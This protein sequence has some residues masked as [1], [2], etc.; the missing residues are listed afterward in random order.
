MK[1]FHFLILAACFST[2]VTAEEI[3]L[4]PYLDAAV[5]EANPTTNYAKGDLAIGKTAGLAWE[6]FLQFDVGSLPANA[7]LTAAELRLASPVGFGSG[8]GLQ[9]SVSAAGWAETILAWSNR[10]VVA[11]LADAVLVVDGANTA[12]LPLPAPVLAHLQDIVRRAS[13]NRGLK[14]SF[15]TAAA[16]QLLTL[17]S[18]ESTSRPQLVITYELD[19]ELPS[20]LAVQPKDDGRLRAAIFK[21]PAGAPA[22]LELVWNTTPG[23]RYSLWESPDLSSWSEVSG[24]PA[25]A[26]ALSG[27]HEIQTTPP[28][29]FF[30]VELID[31][32]PP[33]IVSRSPDDGS[34]GIKRYYPSEEIG[35]RLKDSTGINPAS[36]SLT[37]GGV[38]TFTTASP[39]LTYNDGLLTLDLGGDTPL[40][41]YGAMINASLTVAD[42]LGNAATYDWS[43][44]LEREIVL[45]DGLFTFGSP[46]AQRTG[47]RVPPIPTR[48]LADRAGGGGPIRMNDAEWTL[49]SVNAGSLVIA[50]TGTSAPVFSID[51]YLTNMTPATLDEIFYRKVTSIQDNAATKKLTLGTV[52]VPA[53]EIVTEASVSLSEDDIAFEADADGRIIRAYQM[54]SYS[55]GD[56][57]FS[58]DP[59]QIDWSDKEVMGLYENSSGSTTAV[60]GLPI[61]DRPPQ[62]DEEWDCKLKLKQAVLRLRPS[63]SLSVETRRFLL[64]LK[65]LHSECTVE[66]DTV[67]EPE[68][69]FIVPSIDFDLDNEVNK[70]PLIK[71]DF[72][73]PM[74]TTGIW[75]TVSPRLRAEASLTAGLTGTVSVGASG[76][77]SQTMVIDYNKDNDPRLDISAKDGDA[78]FDLIEPEIALGGT[79]G[80]EFKL[81]P[82]I[83]VKVNSLAGFYVNFDP[84]LG[85]DLNADFNSNTLVGADVGLTF[86]GHVN[87]GMSVI[88]V[89]NSLLPSFEPWEVFD[90][91]WRWYF[92]ESLG[93]EPLQIL[94][95]PASQTIPPGDN[96]QLSVQANHE[97]GVTYEWRHNG[98]R[99]FN[100]SPTLKL[101]SVTS[102]AAGDYKVILRYGS[103]EVESAV[104]TVTVAAPPP[105]TNEFAL[106]PA[107]SFQMGDSL[108]GLSNAPVHS[109]YVSEFYM[110]RYE[111]TKELWDTVRAW[112]L[113]NDY[114]DLAVGSGSY[115]SKGA[116]HPV[117]SISWYDMVK[118]CNARSAMENRTPC[119]RVD[120]A[121]YK[122][123]SRN[124][125]TC[126]W[127]AD[128]YRLPTEAE[129]EKAARGSLSG[130]RFPWGDTITHSQANYYSSSSYA[131]DVSPTRGYHPTYNDGVSPYSSPVGSFDHNLYGLYDMAGNMWERCWDWYG[132]GY[133]SDPSAGSDPR[134]PA[135][136][137]GRVCRGGG[138]N[139]GAGD[140][141]VAGRYSFNP[142]ST[143][144]SIGFRIARSS[145][146]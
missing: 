127:N 139:Y 134:G 101:Y 115:A 30:Q 65:K 98:R 54:K 27:L 81:K 145:V 41:A 124:D 108:D 9:I 123:G 26:D 63:F 39:Q 22:P 97:A 80:A 137:S 73:I 117:H 133:Y 7:V 34:F 42:T 33:L 103:E 10:P 67:L 13:V 15:P 87:A 116:N 71:W 135:S 138:W 3:T 105:P 122:T 37:L 121:V 49:E 25:V 24:Y 43:F 125:V 126:N 131:Y 29:R 107:G 35:I 140:C 48:I 74:G 83:D 8:G 89:S 21:A 38:G 141:R 12:H 144:Y 51:Q 91:E 102:A 52:D 16:D 50:Y 119:Y 55:S 2:I 72:T 99:L 5:S 46:T 82:E 59:I 110:G 129:W 76:G 45:V 130:K 120:G 94:V 23:V 128:G 18:R 132:S 4:N 112:G 69:Q 62:Y 109:V 1:S 93:G 92:P 58:L 113:N 90:K 75:V 17:R 14:L 40:G 6:S 85:A 11:T 78:W 86:N 136:G 143:R 118:W 79:L 53:W 47:Q 19:P 84:A 111:V 68:F 88:G 20:Y 96:L 36:I 61:E 114:T 66:V 31:E 106:I 32:Q 64:G 28:K 100:E 56:K 70:E 95:Q 142:G 146:P 57:K 60:F 104:A 77:Y 44:E